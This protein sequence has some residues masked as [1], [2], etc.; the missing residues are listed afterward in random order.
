LRQTGDGD[1]AARLG[2]SFT[3]IGH[4]RRFAPPLSFGYALVRYK[5]RLVATCPGKAEA[6]AI[7][8]FL[9]GN[10]EGGR[11]LHHAHLTRFDATLR[12]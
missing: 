9:N 11:R 7:A 8:A 6:Q 5:N 1:P 2:Y 4:G 12:Y 10:L 3:R